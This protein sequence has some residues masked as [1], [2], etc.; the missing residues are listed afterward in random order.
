MTFTGPGTAK[1]CGAAM[2]SRFTLRSGVRCV[3]CVTHNFG[4]CEPPTWLVFFQFPFNPKRVP[5]KWT[6]THMSRKL[7]TLFLKVF[8]FSH[9]GSKR[10]AHGS[11]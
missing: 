7:E 9:V 6:H 5:S 11:R 4:L 3:C 1:A 8:R 10:F 2:C